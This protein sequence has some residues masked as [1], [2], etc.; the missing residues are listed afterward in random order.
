[1]RRY[2]NV[3]TNEEITEKEFRHMA[4]DYINSNEWEDGG[5]PSVSEVMLNMDDVIEIEE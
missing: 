4:I 2:L 3:L 1:M 5:K